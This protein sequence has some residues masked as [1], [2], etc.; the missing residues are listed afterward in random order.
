MNYPTQM[1]L[2]VAVVLLAACGPDENTSACKDNLIAGDLVITEVF[3]DYAAPSGGTGTDDGKEWF[4]IY[5]NS[6]RPVSLQGVTIVHSRPD[7]SKSSSHSMTDVTVAP[8]QFFTL[9]NSTDDLVPAY[10]DYGYSADL[11]DFF[12]SDGGKLTLKCGSSEIDSATYD[13]VKSGHSRQLGNGGPP[14]YTLNDEP[15]N[16]CEAKD[17]EFEPNNFGTP[18]QDNDCA[19]VIAGSCSDTSGMRPVVSPMPGDLVITEVMPKPSAV[20]ATGGQWFEVKALRDVDLNGVG[21][22]RAN[23]TAN[24]TVLQSTTCIHMDANSY[25]VF[26]RSDDMV[27]NGGLTTLGTFPFSL[28]PTTNTPDVQ[29]V[30]GTTILDAVSWTTSTSGRSRALDPAATDPSS[31]DDPANF[32]DGSTVYNTVGT[33]MDR[34][35]PGAMNDTCPVQ[36]GPG[37]CLDTNGTPRNIVKP[38]ANTLVINEFLANAAGSGTDPMQEW[39][40]VTN[41]GTASFD[42]NGLGIQ[43]GTQTVYVLNSTNCKPVPANGFALFAHLTDPAQN[44]GLNGVD[45]TF[46]FALGSTI[47]VLDGAVLLDQVTFGTTPDGVSKQLKPTN[48]NATDNDDIANFCDAQPTQ[49]YGTAENYG[50]PKAANVCL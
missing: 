5:N 45:F 13:T 26:A 48:T 3:A 14:D 15:A 30:L 34:G 23:D 47:K 17:T 50:T 33:A 7:G 9:G 8:G 35:T 31:N 40:E 32:C 27:M 12:N 39:F 20:S 42:L 2:A 6:D 19:P 18:G 4:E 22:D 25:A 11:G 16:W 46:T 10:V 29:L 44:G 28:N 36:V 21:I 41:T 49:K 38:P 1:R 37:Q 43:G 24:P